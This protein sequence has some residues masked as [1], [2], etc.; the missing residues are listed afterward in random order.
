MMRRLP[1][2]TKSAFKK[3][4]E[5][6]NP[7]LSLGSSAFFKLPQMMA[8]KLKKLASRAATAAVNMSKPNYFEPQRRDTKGMVFSFVF[9]GE[10]QELRSDLANDLSVLKKEA[11]KRIIAFM[12]IGRDVS[13]LFA[14]VIKCMQTSDI[15]QKKLVY[16]YLINYAKSQPDLVIL[17]INTLCKVNDCGISRRYRTRKT[18]IR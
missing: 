1:P 18:G 2:A 10:L 15:E 4:F 13:P 5:R 9:T 16:L 14:D 17:A 3:Y 8:D 6:E 7:A 12:T 11:L